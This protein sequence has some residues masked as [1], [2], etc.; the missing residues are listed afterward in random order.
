MAHVQSSLPVVAPSRSE[1]PSG[2]AAPARSPWLWVVALAAAAGLCWLP[3]AGRAQPGRGG[4][5]LL[6][7]QW[8]PGSSLYGDYFVDR[9]P[10]VGLVALADGRRRPAL[11]VLGLLAVAVAVVPACC[12]RR[13][14]RTRRPTAG[15]VL[16][17]A[18]AALLTATPL[19]G[20][21]VV[22]GEVL[23]LPFLLGGIAASAPPGRLGRAALWWG[24]LAG[25]PAPAAPG[26]A[27]PARR[28]RVRRRAA[29]LVGRRAG[30]G[31]RR[32][33]ARWRRRRVSGRPPPGA[34]TRA[35]CGTP[36][37]SSGSRRPVIASLP[38]AP[39]RADGRDAA[40]PAGQRGAP[41]GRRARPDGSAQGAHRRGRPRC[42]PS[43]CWRGSSSWCW[44]A[45][46]TGSTT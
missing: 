38:P 34:P 32:A 7:A 44:A 21:T 14:G 4:L 1:T 6:A 29:V 43:R 12:R 45:A 8:S 41:P 42:P 15:G 11:R 24:V 13:L 16:P 25:P 46:A 5:L 27:E 37:W 26:E 28:L 23:G 35:S 36:S 31:R 9:P 22:N 2:E 19:F 30:L 10:A 20:G 39:P 33:S 3:Y 17:P 18:T 40:R